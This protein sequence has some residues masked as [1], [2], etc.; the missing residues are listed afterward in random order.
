[1]DDLKVYLENE[2]DQQTIVDFILDRYQDVKNNYLR[3]G[4]LGR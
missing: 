1:M 4:L 2:E 3:I